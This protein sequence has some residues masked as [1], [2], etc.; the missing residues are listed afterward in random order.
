MRRWYFLLGGMGLVVFAASLAAHLPAR[1]AAGWAR[2]ALPPMVELSGVSGTVWHPR[3]RR[4]KVNLPRGPELT[5]GPARVD[6][7]LWRLVTGAVGLSGRLEAYGGR[8]TTRGWLGLGGGWRV[9]RLRG[10]LPLGSLKEADPRLAMARLEGQALV[11]GEGLEGDNR[12][13]RGGELR[14]GLI[15]LQV[16]WLADDRPLGDFSLPLAVVEPGKLEGSLSSPAANAL[17]AKGDLRLDL[18]AG[19]VRF[20]GQAWPGEAANDNIRNALPLLGRMEG[21][22]ALI[23]YRGRLR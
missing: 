13:P 17:R 11:R 15:D 23:R 6:V 18:D 20:T 22:R 21:N 2:P 10:R 7:G 5:L 9:E 19:R 12:G 14:L 4:I 3:I 1:M 8:V 16:A